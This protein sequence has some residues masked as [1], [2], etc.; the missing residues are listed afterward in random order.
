MARR[1]RT[2]PAVFVWVPHEQPL[3][4]IW[5]VILENTKRGGGGVRQGKKGANKGC[6]IDSTTAMPRG[7]SPMGTFWNQCRECTPE[8]S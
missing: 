7:A 1:Q 5:E 8:T 4:S 2:I 3:R 6:V